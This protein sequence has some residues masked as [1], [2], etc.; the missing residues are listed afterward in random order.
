MT[1]GGIGNGGLDCAM[2]DKLIQIEIT[3]H[4][5]LMN[6][7]D[8]LHDA[9][10]DL[11]GLEMDREAG[12]WNASFE[13]E[14]FEDASLLQ[15]RRRLLLFTKY[16]FPLVMS[17]LVLR[18]VASC[19]IE[20]K[21]RI[22]TYTFNECRLKDKAYELVFC[23]DMKMTIRFKD[24]PYGE[25]RD[26]SLLSKKGSF[27]ALGSPFWRALRNRAA[28]GRVAATRFKA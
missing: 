13:R 19:G 7:C 4:E 22:G 23:E 2:N 15:S 17:K 8:L 10:F 24:R 21:S 14:Y 9:R 6:A 12:S 3:D 26:L 5:S 11:A 27:L 16:T 25:L 28:T 18:E 20:D 1:T